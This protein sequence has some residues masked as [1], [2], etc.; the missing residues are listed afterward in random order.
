MITVNCNDVFPIQH[1]LLVYVADQIGAISTIKHHEF[2]LS[3]IEYEKIDKEK[4]ITSIKE[5]LDHI[6]EGNNFRV[7]INSNTIL[8][9]S[10]NGKK[11]NSVIQHVKTLQTCC[12]F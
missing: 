3:P 8:I 2:I 10:I 5:Y 9:K 11:I 6:G 1:K 7:I 12:S 4:V